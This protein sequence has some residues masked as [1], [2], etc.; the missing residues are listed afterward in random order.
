MG[1]D[2]GF[3]LRKETQSFLI[4][5][6]VIYVLWNGQVPCPLCWVR[7]QQARYVRTNWSTL[8]HNMQGQGQFHHT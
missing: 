4:D 8:Q 5:S 3:D 7:R 2:F 6:C 1:L